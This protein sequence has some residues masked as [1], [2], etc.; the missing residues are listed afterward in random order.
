MRP[1]VKFMTFSSIRALLILS[2]LLIAWK[3]PR[4]IKIIKIVLLVSKTT[5]KLRNCKKIPRKAASE[6]IFNC[7]WN[8]TGID[9]I[10][11][12][13]LLKK[14]NQVKNCYKIGNSGSPRFHK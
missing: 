10:K 1:S 9:E 4:I 3:F 11:R 13:A 2:K 7:S 12:S 6:K 5:Q 14:Q 8:L